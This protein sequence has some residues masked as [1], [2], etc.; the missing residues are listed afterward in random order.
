MENNT[1]LDFIDFE[2]EKAKLWRRAYSEIKHII[3]QKG[4]VNQRI[5]L[6]NERAVQY[7]I[8][9]LPDVLLFIDHG[10]NCDY[11]ESFED[12]VLFDVYKGLFETTRE[13]N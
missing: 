3:V 6:P 11:T 7:V 8:L 10:G 1:K 4:L 12:D 9:E 13:S 2:E 5:E